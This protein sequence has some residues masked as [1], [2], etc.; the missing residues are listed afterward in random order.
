MHIP[1]A[2]TRSSYKSTASLLDQTFGRTADKSLKSAGLH[3]FVI[4]VANKHKEITCNFRSLNAVK[5]YYSTILCPKPTLAL[6][7]SW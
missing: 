6:K 3:K 5:I 1:S 2:C 4:L 7:Q